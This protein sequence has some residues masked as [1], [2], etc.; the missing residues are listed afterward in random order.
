MRTLLI[1]ILLACSLMLM[2]QEAGPWGFLRHSALDASGNIHLQWQD[3]SEG[4][5][6]TECYYNSNNSAWEMAAT[7]VPSLGTMESLVPYSYGQNLRY[8]LRYSMDY[9]GESFCYLHPAYWDADSF[10][11]ALNKMAFIASDPEGDTDVPE[12]PALDLLDSHCATTTQ[13]MYFSLQNVSGTFPTMVSLTNYNVY[14]AVLSNPE[15]VNDSVAYAMIYS[16]SIPGVLSTGLYKLGMDMATEM[17]TFT[18][19]GNIQSQVSGGTLHLACNF[20]DLTADPDFGA[21]P[22]LSHG[23]IITGATMAISIDMG[24]M[25]PVLAFGDY[26]SPGVLV[27]DDNRYQVNANT[28]PQV[29][30]SYYDTETRVL[31]FSYLDAQADYP[32]IAEVQTELGTIVQAYPTGLDFNGEVD[33]VA[34]LPLEDL[35]LL[36]W[37]FSDNG[38]S[39]VSGT[40]N[41][42]SIMDEGLIPHPLSCRM[43][44]PLN[45]ASLPAR[46]NLQGLDKA[47]LSVQVFN[48]R[49][50]KLGD[51]FSGMAVNDELNLNWD[52]LMQGK[53][54]AS[55]IYF[56]QIKQ[57]NRSLN[58]KFV[59]TK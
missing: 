54:L 9:M 17:P 35:S 16:F 49:G 6:I 19:L 22:N 52:G 21:W 3:F 11:P 36:A 45:P 29:Q 18:R 26:T 37:R 34:Q 46:I 56:L 33:F 31:G 50:Q 1:L 59:I 7:S 10:P 58:Q 27:F 42:S 14:L 32:L 8:R 28:L 48:I 47:P 23:L 12:S 15:A 57:N 43:P 13:K 55:G 39:F 25:E 53:K 30:V 41:P 24:T 40:Y 2:A 38:F 44:N 4:S 5:G 20:A 51:I